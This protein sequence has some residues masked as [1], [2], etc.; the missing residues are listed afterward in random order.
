MDGEEF[1]FVHRT[2]RFDPSSAAGRT[3]LERRY[4]HGHRW[5]DTAAIGELVR[6]RTAVYPLQLAELIDKGQPVRRHIARHP[7]TATI[8]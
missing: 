3:A 5:C 7:G 2:R 8:C 1:Y 6:A 4:I